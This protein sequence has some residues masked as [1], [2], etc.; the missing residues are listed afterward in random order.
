MKTTLQD[1]GELAAI[2]RIVRTLPV[3]RDV[4]VGAGDDCAVVRLGFDARYDLLLKSDPVI[5][6]VHFAVGTPGLAIGHKALGRVLSDIAAMGGE[7]VWGLLNVVA[8]P[9]LPTTMLDAI[10]RGV[11]RLA[12]R[13]GLAIV[14]GDMSSGPHLEL[15][16]FAVGRV[17]RGKAVCRSTARPGDIV[18]VTGS[19]GGSFP[20]GRHL[21]FLPRVDEGRFLRAWAT[22]MIDIS[23]GL[24]SDARHLAKA[25]GVGIRLDAAAIPLSTWARTRAAAG[26]GL[27]HALHDG[28]DFELLFTLPASRRSAFERAWRR[29]SSLRCTAIGLVTPQR[30]RVDC[31][32]GAGRPIKLERHGYVHFRPSH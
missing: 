4:V 17:P 7:P 28:E 11:N 14:G 29:R 26:T 32:D 3:R 1:I 27:T 9:S 2:S 15:H 8:P 25:S 22:A 31:I 21:R 6:G 30:G 18:F 24:A 5:E 16:A 13:H 12:T 20:A 19:L 23:D 10:Y